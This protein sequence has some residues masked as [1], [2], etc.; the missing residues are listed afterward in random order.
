[1]S[2]RGVEVVRV[3]TVAEMR[4]ATTEAFQGADALIMTAAV[5]D[6]RPQQVAASKIKKAE[7]GL[8]LDLIPTE[9]FLVE[10]GACKGE[11]VVVGF[12]ME[13]EDGVANARKKL[14]TKR[15]DL[16][17]LNDLTVR[18][19]GFGVDTMW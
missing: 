6:F 5:L 13:T 3:R 7:E 17:V 11:R 4:E 15:L 14:E 18:G 10:L 1:M 19:A 16:I 9:D 2:R 8:R 12:A